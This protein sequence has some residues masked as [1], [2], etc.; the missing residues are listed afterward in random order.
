MG[1]Y[2]GCQVWP[3]QSGVSGSSWVPSPTPGRQ[4]LKTA[5][6]PLAFGAQSPAVHTHRE[7][8]AP[9]TWILSSPHAPGRGWAGAPQSSSSAVVSGVGI[10][11][12]EKGCGHGCH[13]LAESSQV[14]SLLPTLG[15]VALWISERSVAPV[16]WVIFP[17]S[18]P[19]QC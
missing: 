18:H 11:V 12:Q 1:M 15:R 8:G 3:P 17:L 6:L 9:T 19:T 10:G 2:K 5:S 7:G 14:P 16:S 4:V 13:S